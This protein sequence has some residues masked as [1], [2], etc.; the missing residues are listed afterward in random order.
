MVRFSFVLCHNFVFRGTIGL[1][2]SVGVYAFSRETG[3]TPFV[4]TLF[5]AYILGI[6]IRQYC[7]YHPFVAV[8]IVFLSCA[9]KKICWNLFLFNHFFTAFCYSVSTIFRIVNPRGNETLLNGGIT[10]GSQNRIKLRAKP[11]GVTRELNPSDD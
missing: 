10:L 5:Y 1:Q 11:V 9:F 2:K 6:Y 8:R 4:D 3:S 7:I